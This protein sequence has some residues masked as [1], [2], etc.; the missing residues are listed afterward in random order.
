MLTANESP[1]R[2]SGAFFAG[3]GTGVPA[4]PPQLSAAPVQPHSSASLR[5]GGNHTDRTMG[6]ASHS[7]IGAPESST[8]EAIVNLNR[9]RSPFDGLY[10]NGSWRTAKGG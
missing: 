8:T 10:N 2:K 9:A 6:L 4:R 7:A 5:K 1:A 3:A